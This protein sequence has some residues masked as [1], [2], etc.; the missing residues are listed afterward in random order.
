MIEFR[1]AADSDREQVAKCIAEAFKKDFSSLSKD[2]QS[3][4]AAIA[5]GIQ[6]DRFYVA[7]DNKAIVGVLAVSDCNGRSILT[8]A[9]SNRKHFGFVRGIIA[10]I[11][12]KE[13]FEKQ[14]EYP[15]TVGYIEFVAVLESYRRRGI[16]SQLLSYAMANGKYSRYELDVTDINQGAITCYRKYGFTEYKREKVKHAKQ[17]GFSEKIYMRYE[18]K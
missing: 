16:A 4:A 18:N 3:V 11:V 7:V 8:N 1:K 12:F 9:K 17:K 14:L 15:S 10:T 2:T 6:T 13:E 5:G